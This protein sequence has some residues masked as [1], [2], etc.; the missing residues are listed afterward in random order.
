M[1]TRRSLLGGA[2]SFII[3][4]EKS[5]RLRQRVQHS[6]KKKAGAS[7]A[8]RQKRRKLRTSDGAL[9]GTPA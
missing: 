3:M 7:E 5:Y 2:S 8:L 1:A 6:N 4:N 9:N